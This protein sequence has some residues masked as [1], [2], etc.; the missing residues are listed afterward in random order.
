MGGTAPNCRACYSARVRARYRENIE[1]C[2]AYERKRAQDPLR[3]E[4]RR[5]YNRRAKERNPERRAARVAVGNAIRDG[6]LVRQP[7][8]VCGDRGEAHHDDYA[9]PLDVRWLCFRCHREREHGQKVGD[10]TSG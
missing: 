4:R 10:R 9:R 7:C 8:E 3:K 5:E 2:R 6:R 1:N